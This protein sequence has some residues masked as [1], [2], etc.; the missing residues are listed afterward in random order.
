MGSIAKLRI[1]DYPIFESKNAY[2]RE[3]VDSIF[4]PEDFVEESN[5]A[6]INSTDLRE[7]RNNTFKG[8]RQTVGVCRS[9]LSIYGET[10]KNAKEDFDK[11]K[12]IAADHGF[13]GYPIE[14]TSYA[15]YIRELKRIFH[16][17]IIYNENINDTFQNTLMGG[18][19]YILGQNVSSHLFSIFS[20]LRD[21]DIVEYDLTELIEGGWTSKD[22]ASQITIEKVIILTEGKTD[23]EFI[24]GSLKLLYPALHAY[25][26]FI[27][28]DGF[29]VE[30]GASALVKLIKA[31]AGAN[32]KH[33]IIALFDNDTAGLM[34]M[35]KLNI[36]SF[37]LNI[38]VMKLP[39]IKFAN[40]YPTIGPT[41]TKNMNINGTA[42]GIEMYLGKGILKKD[43]KYIPIRWKEY[44]ESLN[45][46]HGALH[47]KDYVQKEFRK[48][49]ANGEVWPMEEMDLLL[50]AVFRAFADK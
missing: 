7:N 2:Y 28:F 10:V 15:Q 49:I 5:Q 47:E 20:V 18:D 48:K 27:D 38:R 12:K 30:G 1:A 46:Y 35:S 31:F 39:D 3:V 13:Y 40:K 34:E 17:G 9:R 24:S 37:P 26:H 33:S 14:K 23:A 45:K 8:F 21:D 29:K 4:L 50:K 36:K 44:S 42:C 25:Y 43:N 22:E 19:L 41:G 6:L 32:V 16:E 11:A